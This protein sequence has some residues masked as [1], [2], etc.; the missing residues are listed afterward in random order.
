MA[1]AAV[2][3]SVA[4]LIEHE[5]RSA[6]QAADL[7]KRFRT[8]NI[9]IVASSGAEASARIEADTKLWAKLIKDTGMKAE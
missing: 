1:P 2:P 3:E 9:E 4:T 5:T 7:V 6:L 8:Q